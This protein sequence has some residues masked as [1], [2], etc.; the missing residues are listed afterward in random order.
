M[1]H[2]SVG[3]TASVIERAGIPT[4]VLSLLHEVTKKVKPPRSLSVPF[5]FGYPL[6]QAHNVEL[7]NRIV[8]QALALLKSPLALPTDCSLN[9]A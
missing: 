3:L 8:R 6:G 9:Q 2:Q 5:G 1:C 4:V 7:Q